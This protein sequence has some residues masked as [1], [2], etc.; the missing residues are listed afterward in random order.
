[1][2]I[3][4]QV[5]LMRA[6]IG[7]K[8]ME[9]DEFDEKATNLTG[10]EAEKC[11]NMIE[12]LRKDV[13]GYKSIVDDLKDGTNDLTGDLWDITSL[14]EDSLALYTEFYIPSLSSEDRDEDHRAMDIKVKYAQDLARMYLIH[15][16]RMALTDPKVLD[17]IMA[18]EE[19]AALIGGAILDM[20][21]LADL[22]EK[23]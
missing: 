4:E 22:I 9:I 7:R 16:G 19:L 12:F 20:P 11:L 15:I 3:R 6:V 1:M 18:N 5:M 21:E 10:E 14:P 8:I 23:Q 17:L 2:D 13:A